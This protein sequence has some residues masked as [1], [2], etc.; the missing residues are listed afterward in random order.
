MMS[1]LARVKQIVMDLLEDGR[2]HTSDELREQIKKEGVELPKKSSTLRTAIYQLRNS[3]IEIYSRDRGVYQIQEKEA[4]HTLLEG[5]ITLMPE[6]KVRAC[7]I[8][9]HSD[10]NL[11]LNGELNREIKSR[12]IE[13]CINHDG[14]KIA[15]IPD[16]KNC[17][18]F[19]KSGRVKNM[20][21]LG[22]LR[23][24]HV[25]IPAVFEMKKNENADIWMGEICKNMKFR[26]KTTK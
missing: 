5:F 10:G 17:H 6:Q 13:I 1:N 3:G 21:L 14:K 18:K 20:E 4:A 16:G 19:T 25:S 11:V 7:Y 26:T 8:Y 12:E 15:L 9:V 24:G 23:R 2:E 22:K